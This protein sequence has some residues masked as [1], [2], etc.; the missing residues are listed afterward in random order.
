VGNPWLIGGDTE[1]KVLLV[2]RYC[3][4]LVEHE[5][6]RG[7][8]VAERVSAL[9]TELE[10]R[11]K[12][13]QWLHDARVA[14]AK[15][16]GGCTV[17]E[18]R[19]G[20][21]RGKGQKLPMAATM[22]LG[23][24]GL[25]WS[26]GQGKQKL[27]ERATWLAMCLGFDSGLR[28][29]QFTIREPGGPDHCICVQDCLFSLADGEVKR[30]GLE[31]WGILNRRGAAWV[32]ECDLDFVTHKSVKVTKGGIKLKTIGRRSEW[33]NAFL[34][35]WVNWLL[36]ARPQG[37]DELFTIR[38][39]GR[40]VAT[41]RRGEFNRSVKRVAVANGL[42]EDKF[43]S[44]SLRGGFASH[45]ERSG[46][47]GEERNARGTWAAGSSVPEQHYV[48]RVGG[49]GGMA[50]GLRGTLTVEEISRMARMT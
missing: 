24:K 32:K 8:A 9:K 5:D 38:E 40:V 35:D 26:A 25:F 50:M 31:L 15:K 33:E 27:L 11:G 41:L 17:Q 22:V 13:V 43:S 30:G 29:G 12:D 34:E 6:R 28:V 44:K 36:E 19:Q 18:R 3:H 42:P 37:G 10:T 23:A 21:G 14:R 1:Q 45:C 49:E 2:V 46:R 39:K 16:A 4:W 48:S 7:G 47:T 20:R